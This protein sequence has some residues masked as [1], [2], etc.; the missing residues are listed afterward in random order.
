MT[1][2]QAGNEAE[3]QT[4]LDT[5]IHTDKR[6]TQTYR[7]ADTHAPISGEDDFGSGGRRAKARYC[8]EH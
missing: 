1:L 8:G 6:C 5:Q 4:S 2:T 7:N 3:A